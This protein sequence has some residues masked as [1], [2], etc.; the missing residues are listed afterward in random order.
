[1]QVAAVQCPVRM[2]VGVN[3]KSL[4]AAITGLPPQTLVVAPEGILSGYL[5]HLV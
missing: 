2:D 5:P 1:M 3:L 4:E